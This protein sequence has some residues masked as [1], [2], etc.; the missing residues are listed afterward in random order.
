[1]MAKQG[2]DD[3]QLVNL[4]DLEGVWDGLY[5]GDAC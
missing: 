5:A 4:V 2:G 1:M 3:Q